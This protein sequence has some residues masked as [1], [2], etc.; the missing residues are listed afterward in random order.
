[1]I[2]SILN[3]VKDT[4]RSIHSN[5]KEVLQ[6]LASMNTTTNLDSSI[7]GVDSGIS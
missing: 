6:V 7:D 1:M 5:I 4:L 2:K 3:K